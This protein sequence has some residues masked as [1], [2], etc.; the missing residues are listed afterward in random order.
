MRALPA[1]EFDILKAYAPAI[2]GL[3]PSNGDDKWAGV[4]SSRD[5]TAMW[6]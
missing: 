5:E 2:A 1:W 4:D 6:E 3:D